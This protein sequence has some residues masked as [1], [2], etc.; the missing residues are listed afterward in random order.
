MPESELD[1]RTLKIIALAKQG[2]GGERDAA[3]RKVR[4]ICAKNDLDFDEVMGD[5]P[6]IPR[7]F[8]L[9]Y[10]LKYPEDQRIVV[11]VAARFAT[12]PEHPNIGGGTYRTA[13]RMLKRKFIF[14]TTTLARHIETINAVH[15]YLRVYHIER[16]AMIDAL[17]LAFTS[18]HK[19]FSQFEEPEAAGS[20]KELTDAERQR[21]FKAV[22]MLG[23]L[24]EEVNLTKKIGSG[25]V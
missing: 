24:T 15:E 6:D 5:H 22:T 23:S 20:S 18:K 8:D 10:T 21:R 25:D 12:S 2:I 4:E 17:P 11:Q 3:I 16:Q 14:Y 7:R 19:L 1:S 13:K 9:D